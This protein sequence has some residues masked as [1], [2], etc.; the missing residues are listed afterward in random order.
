MH[1]F[2][3]YAYE[4]A[5]FATSGYSDIIERNG[6]I[7]ETSSSSS[8]SSRVGW[9]V[10]AVIFFLACFVC[11]QLQFYEPETG[12]FQEHATPLM[13]ATTGIARRVGADLVRFVLNI[14]AM[15]GRLLLEAVNASWYTLRKFG[16]GVRHVIAA[17]EPDAMRVWRFYDSAR[18]SHHANLTRQRFRSACAFFMSSLLW[19]IPIG[20]VLHFLV[21][22]PVMSSSMFLDRYEIYPYQ[23]PAWVLKARP[24]NRPYEGSSSHYRPDCVDI[25]GIRGEDINADLLTDI[26]LTDIPHGLQAPPTTI[27]RTVIFAETK[28]SEISYELQ[29]HPTTITRTVPFAKMT[30]PETGSAGG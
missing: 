14:F 4:V 8:S 23:A 1:S 26:G 30:G 12:Q 11:Y 3:H 5:L 27:T 18:H 13:R 25:R 6:N 28:S 2:A 22:L 19:A 24:E 16:R 29:A 10:G 9:F 15:V 20:S 7:E 17:M 21:V